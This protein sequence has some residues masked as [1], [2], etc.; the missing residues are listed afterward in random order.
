MLDVN[1]SALNTSLTNVKRV[2]S[3][4]G[5]GVA[6]VYC[7]ENCNGRK[8]PPSMRLVKINNQG[9]II[10]V[11]LSCQEFIQGLTV[12]G[13]SLYSIFGNGTMLQYNVKIWIFTSEVSYTR[14]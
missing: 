8:G 12:L 4:S 13:G 6:A 1:V 2:A 10:Q 11:F 3:L 14:C 5:G 9:R 7:L